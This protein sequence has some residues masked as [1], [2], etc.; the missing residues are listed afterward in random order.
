MQFAGGIKLRTPR[1]AL[2]QAM[3]APETVRRCLPGCESM[4]PVPGSDDT[5]NVV[6]KMGVSAVRGTYTGTVRMADLQ[7]PDSFQLKVDAK[8][9]LGFVSAT[10]Q[11]RLNPAGEGTEVQYEAEADMH[12]MMAAVGHRMLAGI[13]KM[14]MDQFL[15]TVERE[16]QAQ[17]A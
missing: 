3:T 1:S 17:S 8:G 16:I 5:Y 15:R 4:E 11:F 14:V 6:V 12:G 10:V 13:G 9:A 2:W 7:P